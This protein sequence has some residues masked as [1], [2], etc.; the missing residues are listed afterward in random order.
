[1]S[2]PWVRT[3]SVLVT[4]SGPA[5][6][7]SNARS[8][9]SAAAR[10]AAH[11]SLTCSARAR[12]AA[13]ARVPAAGRGVGQRGQRH[14]GVGDDA[15]GAEPVGVAGIDVDAREPHRG[16]GEQRVGRGGEVGQ[17]RPDGQHQVGLAGQGVGRRRSFQPDAADLP[18][19]PLLHG[20]LAG[21]GLQHRDAG[22]PGEALELGGGPGVD[23]AAARDD[24]R[25]GRAAS[26]ARTARPRRRS[27]CGR[28][29]PSPARRRTRPG[30]R[31][32]GTGC[33]A[34]ARARRRRRPPGR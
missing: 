19:G 9:S 6:A 13:G 2:W 18:P 31:R 21:E 15:G 27:G 29:M 4:T 34:A 26:R 32:R 20:A 22:G 28:R 25:P 24:Q 8:G 14:A 23:D 10:A 1:M 11:S 7:G 12:Q 17:P 5:C 16:V 30:S 33:P 3:A